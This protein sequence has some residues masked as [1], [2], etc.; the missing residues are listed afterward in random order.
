MSLIFCLTVHGLKPQLS[1][2]AEILT[3]TK[4]ARGAMRTAK[5]A[6]LLL[7]LFSWCQNGV[8]TE[9][10]SLTVALTCGLSPECHALDQSWC[11]DAAI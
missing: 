10:G 3:A 8:F 7:I 5:S 2:R 6:W 9:A 11:C 4:I 1:Q